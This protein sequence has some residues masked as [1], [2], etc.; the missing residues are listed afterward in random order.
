MKSKD[1]NKKKAPI[2]T[3]V[4]TAIITA[5][6]LVGLFQ[7]FWYQP[8]E[9][10]YNK[11]ENQLAEKG[12]VISDLRALLEKERAEFYQFKSAM[13][14]QVKKFLDEIKE[15]KYK[16]AHRNDFVNWLYSKWKRFQGNFC[17]KSESIIGDTWEKI[18]AAKAE[19]EK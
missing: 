2:I 9:A 18:K 6:V 8:L 15:L 12:V 17:D 10:K 5:I 4:V 13:A 11:A 1:K 16:L 19:A 14:N 7:V 3:I